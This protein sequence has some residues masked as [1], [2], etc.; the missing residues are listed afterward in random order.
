M[1]P[2]NNIKCP[3]YV[4]AVKV[5]FWERQVGVKEKAGHCR[6]SYCKM[7]NRKGKR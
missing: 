1:I 4:R 3:H 6:Y 7:N 5:D 2:C